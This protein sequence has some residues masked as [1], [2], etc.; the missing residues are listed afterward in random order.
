M[1]FDRAASRKSLEPNSKCAAQT[2]LGYSA[3]RLA[4]ANPPAPKMSEHFRIEASF[5]SDL[6]F[7]QLFS[8]LGVTN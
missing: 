4:A 5:H 8:Q 6:L 7:P 3:S 1:L 2:L